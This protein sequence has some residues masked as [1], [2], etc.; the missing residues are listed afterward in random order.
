ME[1]GDE[2]V[3]DI[4]KKFWVNGKEGSINLEFEC[5]VYSCVR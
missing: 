2:L 5:G 4:K 3:I 1:F